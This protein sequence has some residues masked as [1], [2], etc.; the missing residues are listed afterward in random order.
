[1]PTFDFQIILL[2]LPQGVTNFG[3]IQMNECES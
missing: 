3:P 2:L 1:M